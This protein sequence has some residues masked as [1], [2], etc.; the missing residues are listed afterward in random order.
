[1][2]IKQILDA[3]NGYYKTKPYLTLAGDDSG[4]PMLNKTENCAFFGILKSLTPEQLQEAARII[5]EGDY[6]PIM[7]FFLQAVMSP[8]VKTE[9]VRNEKID[10]VV[11][12][13]VNKKSKRVVESRKELLRRFDYASFSEQKKIVKAFLC[14]NCAADVHWA[15]VQTDKMW[16]N[17]YAGYVKKAFE[18]KP[19]ES[20]AL[21]VIHHMPLDYVRALES[22]L[23]MFS[24][25][26]YC[27][28]LADQA[29]DLI[30]KYDLNIFEILYVKA[31]TGGK[32]NLTEQQVEYRFFRFIFTFCQKAL[33]GVY[34]CDDSIMAIP[35]IRRVLW[36]LG[37]LG[38][39][40]ILLQFLQMNGFAFS[41][42]IG[43][44]EKGEFYYAQ[45]W[46]V[47]HYFP[48]ASMVE[49]IDFPKVREA[50]EAYI[51][52]RKIKL[53]AMEDLDKYDDLPPDVIDTITDFI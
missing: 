18:Y 6:E 45:L 28:R 14:S 22:Q 25:S 26:E 11:G 1:M 16:D 53:D 30:N 32:V 36:A 12:R 3:L 19:T 21:T 37:E 29:D 50:V 49:D 24:R 2:E 41:E 52:P 15:S 17:S 31:R 40:N 34:H 43:E 42:S 27:I 23:V 5:E 39:R 13:Y 8:L 7:R 48:Y 20:L 38:Y 51:A 35:W 4:S 10:T 33:L 9:P 46:M 44:K 47:D